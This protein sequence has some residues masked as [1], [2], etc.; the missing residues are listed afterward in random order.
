MTPL[1]CALKFKDNAY[2]AAL[3]VSVAHE[4][5]LIFTKTARPSCG[6]L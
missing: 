2:R 3:V 1:R 6:K 5:S 4:T